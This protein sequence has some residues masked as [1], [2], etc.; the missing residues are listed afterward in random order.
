ML[1]AHQRDNFPS[2][3]IAALGTSQ[4][5]HPDCHLKRLLHSWRVQI[6]QTYQQNAATA[7]GI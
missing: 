4:R 2:K 3:K 5:G 7:G 6:R 1:L